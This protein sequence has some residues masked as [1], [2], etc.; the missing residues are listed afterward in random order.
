MKTFAIACPV[1]C[2]AV[3]SCV[4]PALCATTLVI[5]NTGREAVQIGFDRGASQTIAARDSAR[6]TLG[7]GPHTAQCRF[8]GPYDG[9]NIEEQF[10]L[11]DSQRISL[12]LQPVY[13]LQHAV[14]LAQR[15]T[16]KVHTRRDA[17][18]ATKAQDV[19]GAGAECANY[20]SGKLAAISTKIQ[21]GMAVDELALATQRLC[22]E[23]RPVVS[24]TID[25]EKMYVQPDF[26]V[27]R[28]TTGHPI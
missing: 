25:G 17:V 22:G 2:L 13:T 11:A 7:A 20:K 1:A 8:D 16:L 18:W 21:S 23:A 24:T 26:L 5:R 12:D 9:C 15:G 14:T 6:F 19:A 3:L 27:F 28:D 4:A 10:T